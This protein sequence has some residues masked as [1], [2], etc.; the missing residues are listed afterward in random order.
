LADVFLWERATDTF[1]LVS[2]SLL[3]T[4]HASGHSG[5]FAMSADGNWVVFSTNA[6]NLVSGL[7]DTNSQTDLYLWERAT[8]TNRL[9]S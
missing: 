6:T 9:V 2:H 8:N 1:T 3:S 4:L 5:H 7:T